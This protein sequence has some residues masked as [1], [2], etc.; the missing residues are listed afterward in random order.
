MARVATLR[1]RHSRLASS[2]AYYEEKSADQA[3]QLSQLSKSDNFT[4]GLEDD[5]E[6]DE[7]FTEGDLRKAEQEM[8]E[9]ERKKQS[10]E[11]RVTSMEKDLNYR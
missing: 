10:L 3:K 11:E 9:L 5:G 8:M 6:S 1:Q 2:I 4:G 7:I